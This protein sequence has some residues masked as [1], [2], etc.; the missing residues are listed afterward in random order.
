MWIIVNRET[1]KPIRETSMQ[2]TRDYYASLETSYEVMPSL[3][4]LQRYNRLV[5]EAGGV[6]PSPEAFKQALGG[7]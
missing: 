3:V 5:R 6:E 1:G 7:A 2:G 4:W